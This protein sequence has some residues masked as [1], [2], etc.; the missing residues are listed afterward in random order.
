MLSHD[1]VQSIKI[2]MAAIKEQLRLIEERETEYVFAT[3]VPLQLIWEKRKKKER[4]D[5]LCAQLEREQRDSPSKL[6]QTGMQRQEVNTETLGILYETRPSYPNLN[7]SIV[8]RSESRLQITSLRV[9]KGGSVKDNHTGLDFLTGPRLQ[10]EYS[11]KDAKDGEVTETRGGRVSNL[12]PGEAEAFSL[13]LECENTVNLIDLEVEYVSR[14]LHQPNIYYPEGVIAVHCPAPDKNA[15]GSIKTIDR[16]KAFQILLNEESL[17]LWTG[18]KYANCETWKFLFL[19]AAG[20]FAIEHIEDRWS[21]LL[22]KYE[23]TV[24]IGPVLASFAELAQR[25]LVPQIILDYLRSTIRNP[26]KLKKLLV[27]D[28]ESYGLTIANALAQIPSQR[29]VHE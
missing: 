3:E 6:T 13:K 8:N 27:T 14:S 9:I 15:T 2:Q 28:T 1:S 7:F 21:L 10:L 4:L 26:R 23:N 29:G 11:L 20:C 19:R 12:E 24:D 17:N 18:T 22:K 16:N 5:E 25:Y